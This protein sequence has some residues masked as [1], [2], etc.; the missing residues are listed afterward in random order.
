MSDLVRILL[1]HAGE[2]EV[3]EPFGGF[4]VNICGVYGKSGEEDEG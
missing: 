2:G 1:M 4:H 3:R